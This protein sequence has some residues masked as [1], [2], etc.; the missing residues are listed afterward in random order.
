MHDSPY[1]L[2]VKIQDSKQET[3]AG[4]RIGCSVITPTMGKSKTTP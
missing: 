3:L 1:V 2:L 4:K